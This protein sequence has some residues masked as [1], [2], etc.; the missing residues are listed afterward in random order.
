MKIL[1][2]LELE[3]YYEQKNMRKPMSEIN[4]LLPHLF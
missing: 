3:K 1:S 4:T 2:Q